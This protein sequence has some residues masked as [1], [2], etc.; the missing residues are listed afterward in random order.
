MTPSLQAEAYDSLTEI[1][2]SVDC[3]TECYH[4]LI[5][6]PVIERQFVGNRIGAL[7]NEGFSD[8]CDSVYKYALPMSAASDLV[9]K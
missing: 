6:H 9:L 8:V 3:F 1:D 5:H 7:G 2:W 4:G